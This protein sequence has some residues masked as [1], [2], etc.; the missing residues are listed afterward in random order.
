MK[1]S[2]LIE[3]L[4]TMI[5]ENGDLNVYLYLFDGEYG[6]Y[7]EIESVMVDDISKDKRFQVIW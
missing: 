6:S 1:A 7:E 5:D 2:E 4:K 3:E